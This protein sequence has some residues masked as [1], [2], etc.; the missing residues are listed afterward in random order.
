MCV[1]IC[2]ACMYVCDFDIGV[3]VFALCGCVYLYVVCIICLKHM[4]VPFLICVFDL[5]V[6]T[7]ALCMSVLRCVCLCHSSINSLTP[8]LPNNRQYS[9]CSEKKTAAVYA[10]KTNTLFGL[11]GL[12]VRRTFLCPLCCPVPCALCPSLL[13]V[14]SGVRRSLRS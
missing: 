9:K 3:F 7:I 6:H 2:V 12:G 4:F 1:Y 8:D 13:C 14:C 11:C 5:C 10:L